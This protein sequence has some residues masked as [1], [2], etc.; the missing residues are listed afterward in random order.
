MTVLHV[1][2]KFPANVPMRPDEIEAAVLQQMQEL[3]PDKG[4]T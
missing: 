1:I 4:E 2:R 3:V